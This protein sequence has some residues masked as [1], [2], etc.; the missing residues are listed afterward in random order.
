MSIPII[1]AQA[2]IYIVVYDLYKVY[3]ERC[4]YD[5]QPIRFEFTEFNSGTLFEQSEW[6][7][8]CGAAI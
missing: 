4:D 7:F 3:I 6:L 1:G 8:W 5:L 2:K